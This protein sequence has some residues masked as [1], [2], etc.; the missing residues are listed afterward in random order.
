M[1]KSAVQSCLYDIIHS[2]IGLALVH[3]RAV[4]MTLWTR[5]LP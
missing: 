2:I 5:L 1:V 3:F 4:F